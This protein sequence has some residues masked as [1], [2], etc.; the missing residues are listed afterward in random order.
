MDAILKPPYC[1]HLLNSPRHPKLKIPH[2][3][4]GKL[5]LKKACKAALALTPES[6]IGDFPTDL[7]LCEFVRIILDYTS[8]SRK[9]PKSKL[10]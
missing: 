8:T 5:E 1:K 9:Q 3:Y 10:S 2:A 7:I 4:K 6:L